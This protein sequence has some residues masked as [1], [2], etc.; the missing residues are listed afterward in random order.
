MNHL[1]QDERLWIATRL[2]SRARDKSK[3]LARLK[4]LPATAGRAVTEKRLRE[5]IAECQRIATK[6]QGAP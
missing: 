6:L 3:Q 4:K 1:S 2:F 5:E